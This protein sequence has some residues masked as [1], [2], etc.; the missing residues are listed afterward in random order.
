MFT[1]FCSLVFFVLQSLLAPHTNLVSVWGRLCAHQKKLLLSSTVLFVA[2][3]SVVAISPKMD[4]ERVRAYLQVACAGLG[5]DI[6]EVWWTS[7]ENGSS[8]VA[9]IGELSFFRMRTR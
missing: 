5:F 6:G 1:V 4:P 8:T 2:N 3:L 7:N 9:A